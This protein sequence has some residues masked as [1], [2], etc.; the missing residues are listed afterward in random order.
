MPTK[1]IAQTPV[2]SVSAEPASLSLRR[3]PTV[4]SSRAASESQTKLP[5]IAMAM[6]KATSHNS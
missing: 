5:W 1:G 6:D 4:V 3:A 2:V